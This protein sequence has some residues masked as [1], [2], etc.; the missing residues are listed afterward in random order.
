[1]RLQAF[2]REAVAVPHRRRPQLGSIVLYSTGDR[3]HNSHQTT[4]AALVTRVIDH[5]T[6]NLRVFFDM[7]RTTGLRN[8][9]YR[10]PIEG[11]GA[12]WCWPP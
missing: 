11:R 1:M 7:E 8:L 5:D 9:A 12:G 10:L 4:H 3:E 6:V 2:V